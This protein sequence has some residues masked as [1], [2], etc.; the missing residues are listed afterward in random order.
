MVDLTFL[1]NHRVV[2]FGTGI[3]AAKCV[4]SLLI[5]QIQVEYFLNNNCKIQT[6]CNR[7][8]FSPDEN[9]IKDVFIIVAASENALL[10]IGKQ[11][12][13]N[14]LKEFSDFIYY[15]LIDKKMVLLHGNCHMSVI[16]EY[17]ESNETFSKEYCI[18]YN[19]LI[20]HNT[21]HRIREEVLRN[22]DVLVHE[23]IQEDNYCGYYLSDKYIRQQLKNDVKDIT[24]PHLF[25]LGK[26]LFPQVEYSKDNPP[27]SNGENGNGLF[28]HADIIIDKCIKRGMSIEDIVLFVK[29]DE[30]IGKEY[31][32][33][34][35]TEYMKKI[36]E[37]EKCWDIKI[38]DFIMEH[39]KNE[40]LFFDIGHG[41][42][43]RFSTN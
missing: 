35:F 16:K 15:P 31:I 9:N 37:R 42:M 26:M 17:L 33:K 25:G 22:C 34:N 24:M 5:R 30:A 43:S 19:P 39:Y 3:L 8:V 12:R 32:H 10:S 36:K 1:H 4:Y 20:C 40:K 29:S 23:D 7:P 18:Y 28:P 2:I 13:D 38:Y 6:F 11:L 41:L 14:G 27:I 21:E